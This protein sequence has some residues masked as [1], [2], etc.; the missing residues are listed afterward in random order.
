VRR[1]QLGVFP[2]PEFVDCLARYRT[3]K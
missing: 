1:G 2:K 3:T